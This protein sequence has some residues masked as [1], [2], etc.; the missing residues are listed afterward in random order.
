MSEDSLEIEP[1]RTALVLVDLQNFTVA[2]DTIPLSGREVLAN[3]VRLAEA[4]RAAGIVVVLVRVGHSD[5]A[6]PHPSPRVDAVF[7]GFPSPAGAKEIAAELG[8]KPGDVVVDK[9]N[10]GAFYGTNLDSHLRRRGIDTLIMAG[11]VTNIGVDTSM[12]QAQER[13]YEQVM[14][15]DAVAAMS[16]EEHDY[17]LK[18]IAPRLARLRGTDA[19][20]A[21]I[22]RA[23]R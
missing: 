22:A 20:L 6:M 9:Y 15:V 13:G 11:L 1:G 5:N 19:V 16:R 10:W 14:V 21:A 12:R 3:S 2:M 17:T 18:Y 23:C 4:C 8:P 7:G